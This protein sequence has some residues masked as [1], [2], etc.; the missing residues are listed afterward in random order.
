MALTVADILKIGILRN[1]TVIAG[2]KGLDNIVESVSMIEF[3]G[4]EIDGLGPSC[5]R[6][7]E[8]AISSLS[9]FKK[10]ADRFI[11]FTE[12]L[13]HYGIS[14]LVVFYLPYMMKKIPERAIELC[15]EAHFPIIIM[16]SDL[17]YAYVDVL[18][19]VAEALVNDKHSHTMFVGDALQQ[20]IL[21]DDEE[22]TIHS[23]LDI[24]HTRLHTDLI[25]TDT[26][27]HPL[28]WSLNSAEFSP[29]ELLDAISAELDGALPHNPSSMRLDT[30]SPPLEIRFQP[31]RT[32]KLVGMLLAVS[33]SEEY[34]DIDGMTQAGEVLKLFLRVWR[35]TRSR[36]CELDSLL[37]GGAAGQWER[38]IKYL[39]VIRNTDGISLDQ[40]TEELALVRLLRHNDMFVT[41]PNQQITYF[42]GSL[43][44]ADLSKKT[45]VN[46][47]LA[48]MKKELHLT[49]PLCAG[50]CEKTHN[51]PI[52]K[53][54]SIIANALPFAYSIFPGNTVFL[55][56]RVYFAYEIYKIKAQLGM[57]TDAVFRILNPLMADDRWEKH[58]ETLET[59][60]LDC[61]GSIP[62]TAK[63]L[64]IHPNTMKYRLRIIS[65]LL[66]QD[67]LV[68]DT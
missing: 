16:P 32:N 9:Y 50:Q 14:C 22:Q 1:A 15:N 42:S 18:M 60:F 30:F 28:D 65:E 36:L 52:Q 25:L 17:K 68:F 11:S 27:L 39:T 33:S 58:R 34:F 49:S 19:P 10:S 24:L 57:Q 4:F 31:V 48:K 44:I 21:M 47:I 40:L 41:N 23:L 56:D 38:K 7:H 63:K 37:Q 43:V 55:E 8:L 64:G 35:L 61:N 62:E 51:L 3:D 12:H 45:D 67:I 6:G 53:M 26:Q 29:S 13:L 54:Y 5:L 46:Q 59:F 66:R 20:L 2:E